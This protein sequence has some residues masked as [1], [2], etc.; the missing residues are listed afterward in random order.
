MVLAFTA[1]TRGLAT[2]LAAAEA[3]KPPDAVE[4]ATEGVPDAAPRP[5]QIEPMVEPVKRSAPKTPDAK[6]KAPGSG[7]DGAGKGGKASPA[8]G[9]S[10]KPKKGG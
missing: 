9:K 8:P 3:V 1:L 7:K 4:T 2:P 10:P 5:A 6:A